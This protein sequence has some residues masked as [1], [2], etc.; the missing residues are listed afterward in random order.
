MKAV[1]DTNIFISGIFWEGNFC[2][3]IIDAWKEGKFELVSSFSIIEELESVLRDF[4]IQMSEEMINEW[5]EIIIKNSLIVKPIEILDIIKDDSD[6]N[7]FIEVAVEGNVDYIVSQDKHLLNLGEFR[8]IK[9]VGP[10]EFL[11]IVGK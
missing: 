10:E 11:K 6:D 3:L 7:K 5:K 1:L 9:I 2:S 8:K 4:K